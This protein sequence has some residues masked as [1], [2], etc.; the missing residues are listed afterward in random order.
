MNRLTPAALLLT[1]LLAACAG[2]GP[3]S[4]PVPTSGQPPY[5]CPDGSRVTVRFDPATER[6]DLWI[7]RAEHHLAAVP[8]PNGGVLYQDPDYQLRRGATDATVIVTDRSTTLPQTC[9]R[10][11]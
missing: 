7:G 10:T 6:T 1:C 8:D 3:A 2:A 11:P 5:R 9:V 4:A